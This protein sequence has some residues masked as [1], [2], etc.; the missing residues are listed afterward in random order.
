MKDFEKGS[1]TFFRARMDFMEVDREMEQGPLDI[2]LNQGR[3]QTCL[4]GW[5]DIKPGVNRS[6]IYSFN[7]SEFVFIVAVFINK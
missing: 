1:S 7:I 6:L 2:V 5:A 4:S 3:G